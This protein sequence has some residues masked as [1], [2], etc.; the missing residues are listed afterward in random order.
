MGIL[1]LF[2]RSTRLQGE[3]SEDIRGI[4]TKEK[5]SPFQWF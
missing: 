4:A 1:T 5:I 3:V 2:G